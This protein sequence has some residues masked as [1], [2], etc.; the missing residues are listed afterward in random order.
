M[1]AVGK[2]LVF[3]NLVFS[4]VVGGLVVFAYVALTHRGAEIKKLQNQ[5]TVANTSAQ[6]YQAEA[7][8]AKEEAAADVAKI[9][10]ELQSAQQGLKTAD[11]TIAQLRRDLTSLQA[12]SNQQNALATKY[13]TEVDKRQDD[14]SQLH[15]ELRKEKQI[16]TALVR[17]NADLTDQATVAQIE[18]RAVQDQNNRLEKQLQQ[19][20]KDNARMRANGTSAT[21]ARAGGKNPPPEN[22]EG[23]V[24]V[25]DPSSN[26][27]T[28]TI[29]SD[30]GL[31]KGHTLELFRLNPD[32]PTQSKYLGTVRILEADAKQ[33]VVQPVGRL[34]DKPQ[35]GDRVASRILGS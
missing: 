28:I 23:L 16:N 8:K 18:R 3:L 4:L 13:T 31:A 25:T 34:S 33:A 1:T 15:E 20:A 24:K 21:L 26:L 27:M 10:A 19:M 11:T 32:S 30:A 35:A 7:I 17:K 29:G 9:R 5:V 14:V 22:V 12:K 2:I 6:T